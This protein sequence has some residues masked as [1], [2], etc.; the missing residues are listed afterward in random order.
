MKNKL[1]N[2]VVGMGVIGQGH[3][4]SVLK[5]NNANLVAV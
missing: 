4:S 1:N 3:V 5:G 2:A